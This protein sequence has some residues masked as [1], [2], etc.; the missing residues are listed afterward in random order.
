MPDKN[1]ALIP[2]DIE[3]AAEQMLDDW[4]QRWQAKIIDAKVRYYADKT[5]PWL[6]PDGVLEEWE[7]LD[8]AATIA[9]IR[10]Y[11]LVAWLYRVHQAQLA[12]LH[13]PPYL[14]PFL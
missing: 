9:D 7:R 12:V 13:C 5:P 1:G 8:E 10:G 14:N 2:E 11:H 4:R 6:L 3:R